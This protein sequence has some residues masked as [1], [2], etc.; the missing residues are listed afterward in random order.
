M[1]NNSSTHSTWLPTWLTSAS[2]REREAARA[3]QL[4]TTPSRYWM[5][6]QKLAGKLSSFAIQRNLAPSVL[7]CCSVG[8]ATASGGSEISSL[9]SLPNS[10]SG[11]A[12]PGLEPG[13]NRHMMCTIVHN[14][15][16]KIAQA[17]HCIHQFRSRWRCTLARHGAP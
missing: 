11:L 16:R 1:K 2:A 3:E 10:L 9:S 7:Y 5:L 12:R 4:L 8:L 17:R 14:I 13:S 6:H 15:V